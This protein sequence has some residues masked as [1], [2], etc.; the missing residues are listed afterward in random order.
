MTKYI[1]F[2]LQVLPRG[3]FRDYV[4]S[5]DTLDEAVECSKRA[6]ET[7]QFQ[8]AYVVDMDSLLIVWHSKEGELKHE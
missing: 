8:V 2:A 3:G 6:L 5:F 1:M 4:D 7:I